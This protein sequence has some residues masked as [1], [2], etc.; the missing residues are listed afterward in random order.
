MKT[1][2]G[3]ALDPMP[4]IDLADILPEIDYSGLLPTV[5]IEPLPLIDIDDLCFNLADLIKEEERLCETPEKRKPKKPSLKK[6]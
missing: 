2:D 5:T 3:I 1:A 6:S 4:E